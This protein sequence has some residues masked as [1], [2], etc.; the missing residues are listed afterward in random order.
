LQQADWNI[1]KKGWDAHVLGK[2]P[3]KFT[4]PVTALK[5]LRVR[6]SWVDD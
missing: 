5:T 3:N 4:D 6:D 2:A 1:V